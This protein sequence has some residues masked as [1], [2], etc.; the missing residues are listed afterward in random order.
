MAPPPLCLKYTGRPWDGVPSV[1]YWP[2]VAGHAAAAPPLAS[3]LAPTTHSPQDPS[4]GAE[5]DG[6]DEETA[7]PRRAA[8]VRVPARGRAPR[9]GGGGRPSGPRYLLGDEWRPG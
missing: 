2:S 4:V 9:G 5:V 8:S 6:A 1:A 3:Q 7:P